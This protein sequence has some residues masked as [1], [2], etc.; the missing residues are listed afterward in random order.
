MSLGYHTRMAAKGIQLLLACILVSCTSALAVPTR[1]PPSCPHA[2]LP[3]SDSPRR[4]ALLV[5]VG[6]YADPSIPDLAGPVPDVQRMLEL[7]TRPEGYGFPREN[8]CVLTDSDATTAQFLEAFNRTLIERAGPDDTILIYFAGHGSQTRDMN[9]D[10]ADEYDETLVLSDARTG[11]IPDFRDDDLNVLLQQLY[12]KT[13]DITV[14]LDACNSGSASRDST[15]SVRALPPQVAARE[16]T[17]EQVAGGDAGSEWQSPSMPEGVVLSAAAD[18]SSALEKRGPSGAGGVFTTAL[19]QVLSEVGSSPWTW[20]QVAP[21]IRQQVAAESRQIPYFQ[22]RLDRVVFGNST[23]S[24]PIAWTVEALGREDIK[25]RGLPLPGWEAGALVRIY[26]GDASP[27][28]LRDPQTA[29]A[30]IVL[31]E[32]KGFTAKGRRVLTSQTSATP[33]QPGDLAVLVR[34]GEASLGL[35]V[36]LRPAQEPGGVPEARAQHIRQAWSKDAEMAA[37][38]TW[39]DRDADL[40]LILGATGRIQLVDPGTTLLIRNTFD[41]NPDQEPRAVVHSLWQHARRKALLKL[42]GETGGQLINHQTLQVR[43]VPFSQQLPCARGPWVQSLPNTLQ[44]IPLCH[45]WQIQVTLSKETPS[46]LL[47]GGLLLLND[48]GLHGFPASGNLERLEPGST[49]TFPDVFR[50]IPPLGA[51]DDLLIFGTS[52]R[53]PV[54]WHLFTDPVATRGLSD[55]SEASPL[56]RSLARY[57]QPGRGGR[58]ETS[59]VEDAWTSTHLTLRVEASTLP[60]FDLRPYLPDDASSALHRLLVQAHRLVK[61]SEAHG[62]PYRQHGWG[63]KSDEANLKRGVDCSRAIWFAFT[64][65]GLEY[66]RGNVY[67]SSAQMVSNESPMKEGFD[68]CDADAIRIGDVLVYRDEVRSAGH[69]VMVIDPKKRIAWGS[70]GWDGNLDEKMGE[71]AGVSD[72]GV[73]YQPIQY[74]PDLE[75][76]ARQNVKR[77]ACWRHK[78]LAKEW[79]KP[80]GQPGVAALE[81]PCEVGKCGI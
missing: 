75:R 64:R 58:L 6:N 54:S 63:E 47:V 55:M 1:L 11:N 41:P 23:R 42:E 19:V 5:G 57:L 68:R 34:P 51:V 77:V 80:S 33:V 72:R 45:R 2:L 3:A 36:R 49:H 37:P 79:E 65:A 17:V 13:K 69:V 26:P 61:D 81:E 50:A 73:E 67:L 53:E 70:H 59:E 44:P 9:G 35:N 43:L 29:L 24:H 76:S 12:A 16:G 66:N 25:L 74:T 22:G 20:Q 46:P 60:H 38:I 27:S 39:T 4:F 56:S 62:V 40:E 15:L 7:I 52:E 71:G 21:R 10:E 14:I 78:Q 30:S 32:V 48:G 31:T 8:V 28:Q 18:G